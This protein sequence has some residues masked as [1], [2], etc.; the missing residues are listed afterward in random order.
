VDA[1]E[2]PDRL[3]LAA[4]TDAVAETPWLR[5]VG[6]TA[7]A[8][9]VRPAARTVGLD[10]PAN[11]AAAEFDLAHIERYGQALAA[12]GPLDALLPEGDP[13]PS[14]YAED[15]LLAAATPYRPQASRAG[16]TARIN[17]VVAHLAAL[18][19]AVEVVPSAPVTLTAATGEIPVTLVNEGAVPVQV[20]VRLTSSRFDFP[21]GR[22]QVVDLPARASIQP[23]FTATARN[24]GGF[25][26]VTVTVT[27]PAGETVLTQARLS[28]RSTAF[29]VVGLL[30]VVGSALV[31]LLWGVRQGRR[32]RTVGRHERRASRREVA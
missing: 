22:V 20:A 5:P 2:T 29:P 28:V 18:R 9:Q 3:P 10:Y 30:A 23:R 26:A 19:D 32:R 31:L 4:L 11:S 21:D 24:P 7:L 27:D 25:A 15:L 16:A 13:T 6:L 1:L 14:R 12:L 17:R 8:D